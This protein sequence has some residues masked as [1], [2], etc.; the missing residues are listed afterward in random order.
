MT[1]TLGELAEKVG[2]QLSDASHADCVITRVAPLQRAS[3]SDICF[4]ANPKYTKHLADSHASAVIVTAELAEQSP[5]PALI[6]DNPYAT[7]ARI[8]AILK[9]AFVPEA[10]IHA[11]AVV[12]ESA[13]ID[14]SVYIG[15]NAVIDAGVVIKQGSLIGPGCYVGRHSL[16]G[17]QCRIN[18]NVSIYHNCK[19]GNRTIIH[20]GAVIGADG[21]GFANDE[22]QWVKVPQTGGVSIGDDVEIGASTTIDRGALED[23][24]IEDGVKLDNQI[25]VAHNVYIGAH[26]AI[27]GCS[28]IAG[29]TRIGKYCT[30]AGMCTIVGHIELADHVHITAMSL[31]TKSIDKAG[32][33]SSGTPFEETASWRKNSVRFRQLDQ[34][35]KRLG[36]LEKKS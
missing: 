30:I 2:A 1:H 25:Q 16:I 19:I 3:T 32:S 20:S 36:K 8:A 28:G 22:G 21:F 35:S 26:T 14:A 31:I 5:I 27:A 34:L 10:E 23:T 17:E 11:S 6:S 29:S 12:H 24:V 7:Y 13:Q 9:P 18:A 15:P 4:L 33:Y